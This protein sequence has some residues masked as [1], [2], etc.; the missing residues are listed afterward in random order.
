MAKNAAYKVSLKRRR[1]GKTNYYKRYV[2]VLSGKLRLVV[3]YSNKYVWVQIVKPTVL[4]DVVIAAAHSKELY[5]LFD[6][7]GGGK[8]TSASYLTGLLAAVR[9]R[10]MNVNECALDIGLKT[11]SK[12]SKVFAVAKAFRD[13]GIAVNVDE[14]MI[15][16]NSRIRGEVLAKYAEELFNRD[17]EQFKRLFS[18]Y[19]GRGLDPRDLPNH[20]N[21]ILEK[22]ISYAR[23]LGVEVRVGE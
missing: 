10:Y 9:A 16:D 14:E 13:V 23:K 7:R 20:F 11:P 22:I 1:E 4:G 3:R 5:K 12:G 21:N 6:W 8:N 17:P 19:L 2:Q 15:P 18:D